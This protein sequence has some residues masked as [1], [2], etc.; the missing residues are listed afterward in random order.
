MF[1]CCLSNLSICHQSL[2]LFM[3][4]FFTL[5][6]VI[7]LCTLPPGRRVC[8]LTCRT[9]AFP[10]GFQTLRDRASDFKHPVCIAGFIGIGSIL[11]SY[12]FKGRGPGKAL[13]SNRQ[14]IQS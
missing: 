12:E 10:K 1:R 13:A 7:H 9:S 6:I 5:R 14:H 3:F 11:R 4:Y 2:G 8:C